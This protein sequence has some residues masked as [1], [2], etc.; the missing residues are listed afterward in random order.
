M[1]KRKNVRT[2]AADTIESYWSDMENYVPWRDTFIAWLLFMPIWM[3]RTIAW[4]NFYIS[5]NNYFSI[6][7]FVAER[8]QPARGYT[9]RKL[10]TSIN[11]K[12]KWFQPLIHPM[13]TLIHSYYFYHNAIKLLNSPPLG[14][15][16]DNVAKVRRQSGPVEPGHHRVPVPHGQGAV[17][18][19]HSAW[20]QGLLREQH[21]PAT[22]VSINYD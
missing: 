4:R 5:I 18:G 19:H 8:E 7:L 2:N 10:L 13:L 11:T 1:C 17:P 6:V 9:I 16:S 14:A 3:S 22:Q 15:R 12:E 20:A 21:R